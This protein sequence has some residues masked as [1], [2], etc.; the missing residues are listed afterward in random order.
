MHDLTFNVISFRRT[1]Q[2]TGVTLS[3]FLNTSFKGFL[4]SIGLINCSFTHI[5]SETFTQ[6]VHLQSINMS[7]NLITRVEKTSFSGLS[8]LVVIDLRNNLLRALPQGTFNNVSQLAYIYL[9]G[10]KIEAIEDMLFAKLQ[11]LVYVDLSD[12]CLTTV[13]DNVFKTLFYAYDK[14]SSIDLSRNYLEDL[15]AWILQLPFLV[16]VDLS[17]NKMS[18]DSI[19]RFLRVLPTP[20]LDGYQKV[21]NLFVPKSV[22]LS[23]NSFT[24]FDITTLNYNQT[25]KLVNFF[26]RSRLNFG[27]NVFDCNCKMYLLYR[28]LLIID[29]KTKD[30]GLRDD[31]M[32]TLNYNKKGFSCLSPMEFRGKP[33]IQVPVDALG[34]EEDLLTCPKYCRCW[35]R[36]EDRAVKV[37]CANQ[38]FTRLPSLIPNGSIELDFSNN[39]LVDFHQDLPIYT[40][41][42]E[43]LDLSGNRL[44]NMDGVVFTTQYEMTDLRLHNNE[45]TTLPKTVSNLSSLDDKSCILASVI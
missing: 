21:S 5:R 29:T 22:D 37:N 35:V 10:N 14:F 34:C 23:N 31:I 2:L 9:P 13:S 30:S 41:F 16:D 17:G 7:N 40:R 12:N 28:L 25:N 26:V 11:H 6:L 1:L 32:S 4:Y 33:L 43:V 3:N 36:T 44:Q 42:L 18:F 24:D 20:S 27:E 15:P 39:L 45:L 19:R 38:N 8:E